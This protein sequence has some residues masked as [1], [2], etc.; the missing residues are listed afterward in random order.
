MWS[1]IASGAQAAMAPYQQHRD[2]MIKQHD[3]QGYDTQMAASRYQLTV[4]DLQKAGLNPMLA[5]TQG[6]GSAPTSPVATGANFDTD[7]AGKFQQTRVATAQESAIQAQADKTRAEKENIDADT[8]NKYLVPS[9]TA[10]E[11][12][13]KQNSA[14]QIKAQTD[15]IREQIKVTTEQIQNVK[16]QTQKN[17]SDIDVN[18]TLES[19]N[20]KLELLRTAETALTTRNWSILSPKEQASKTPT[21]QVGHGM[22]YFWKAVN[23]FSNFMGK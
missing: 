4:Q 14:E 17:K 5:Y 19:L 13:Y 15:F 3:A 12:D 16:S 21:A 20:Q 23:P 11:T 22:E 18:K 1:A 2:A 10:A 9:L 6:A 8:V 7:A